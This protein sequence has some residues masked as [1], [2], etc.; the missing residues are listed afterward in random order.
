MRNPF[1]LLDEAMP[2]GGATLAPLAKIK[3][4]APAAPFGYADAPGAPGNPF[5]GPALPR[6]RRRRSQND[7]PVGMIGLAIVAGWLI[8]S[9]L[10]ILVAPGAGMAM[11]VIGIV[12]G[13]LIQAGGGFGL[14]I[15][16]VQEDI[17]CGLLYL[18]V[19]FYSLYYLVSRWAEVRIQRICLGLG[20]VLIFGGMFV[21][22][23]TG[24]TN[25]SPSGTGEQHT[26]SND[27]QGS[28]TSAPVDTGGGGDDNRFARIAANVPLPTF[29]QPQPVGGQ[30]GVQVR[31]VRLTGTGQ[32]GQSG[33]LRL[34]L[35]A[36]E[37]APRSLACV[38]VG[39]AGSNLMCGMSLGDGD[40]PEQYPYAREGLAVV[41]FEIDGNLDLET[42]DNSQMRRAY[43]Q[44]SAAA[45][46]IVNAR[47]AFHYAT[48]LMPEVDPARVYIAGHSS[49]A[50]LS[51]LFAAHEPR[52]AGAI[53]YAP[54]SDI[55]G[56]L[57]GELGR[58]QFWALERLL[59]GVE[60]FLRVES[61]ITHASKIRCPVFL[62][63]AE[64]DSNVPI[65]DSQ[66]MAQR[67]RSAGG[68]VTFD[69]VPVGD[70]YDSMIQQGIPRAIG[71]IKAR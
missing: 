5:G 60:E 7:Q 35:P 18:L 42:A 4:A 23:L 47:N 59:P 40:H 69:T 33:R 2:A 62:F 34:Y 46:G 38:L 68:N 19:P 37:H 30:R 39:P 53:A 41:A 9:F 63:H 21:I 49:A 29:E 51:L 27:N 1:D 11:A 16:A 36:G 71:W 65:S 64:N 31:E 15:A 66:M 61:P 32:P 10:V 54:A 13:F 28:N 43:D 67:L 6:K 44:F 14:L 48:T 3:S 25:R 24:G 45:A 22:A 26:A 12:V 50:T 56:R 70:H 57:R 20:L 17:V 55:L 58:V 52:L 8:L